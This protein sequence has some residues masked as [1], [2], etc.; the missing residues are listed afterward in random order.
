MQSVDALTQSN[1][2][3]R[4]LAGEL[5]RWMIFLAGL[6]IL[7]AALII[8]AQSDLNRTHMHRDTALRMEQAQHE[9]LDRYRVFLDELKQPTQQTVDLLA[10]SQLGMIP[11]NRQALT[12]PGQPS[13]PLLFAHLDPTNIVPVSNTIHV[14]KLEMLA[15]GSRSRLWF[16]LIGAVSIMYGL[17]PAAKS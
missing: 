1:Q 8:P 7:V 17:L 2:P 9:R 13:D 16:V 10:V 14:S 15:T 12:L 6:V 3:T 11:T 4:E 5:G